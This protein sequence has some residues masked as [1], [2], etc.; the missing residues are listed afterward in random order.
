MV[1]WCTSGREGG[2]YLVSVGYE[3]VGDEL[4]LGDLLELAR[5]KKLRD[6]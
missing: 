6:C 2:A 3:V 1:S 4:A 5:D